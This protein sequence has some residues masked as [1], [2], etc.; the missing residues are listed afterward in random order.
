MIWKSPCSTPFA[1][2]VVNSRRPASALRFAA[3]QTLDLAGV[4]V[5]ADDMIAGF[6]KAGTR[7]EAHV[8]GAENGYTHVV[9]FF[10]GVF[11]SRT[12]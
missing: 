8:A 12:D 11:A 10:S 9:V 5:H 4:D 7:H 3:V 1:A 2:S 6:G